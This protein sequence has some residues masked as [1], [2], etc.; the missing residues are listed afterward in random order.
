MHRPANP[1]SSSS[2]FEN[3][4][5][6]IT[7]LIVF[8]AYLLAPGA[9]LAAPKCTVTPQKARAAPSHR[10]LYPKLVLP[11]CLPSLKPTFSRGRAAAAVKPRLARVG[12]NI[13]RAGSSARRVGANSRYRQKRQ[14]FVRQVEMGGARAER[15]ADWPNFK[16]KSQSRM[17]N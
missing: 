9:R 2:L 16:L 1:A 11:V 7:E 15:S 12:K 4:C 14:T 6:L 5:F 17:C 3:M 8:A 13:V 10:V